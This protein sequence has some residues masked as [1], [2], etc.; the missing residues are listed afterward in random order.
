MAERYEPGSTPGA[1]S[2]HSIDAPACRR[3]PCYLCRSLR[4]TA[5]RQS[6]WTIGCTLTSSN[7]RIVGPACDVRCCALEWYTLRT[8]LPFV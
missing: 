4:L 3:A 5:P 2:K 1:A 7:V 8:Q 6:K